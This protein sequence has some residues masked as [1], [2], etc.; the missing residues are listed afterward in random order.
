M[1]PAL[2]F[3]ALAERQII[4]GLTA[5]PSRNDPVS[6]SLRPRRTAWT[7]LTFRPPT[8]CRHTATPRHPSPHAWPDLLALMTIEEKLAQLGSAWVF[9]L[10]DHR[11]FDVAAATGARRRH[12][13]RHT[14]QRRAPRRRRRV[15]ARQRHPAPPPR[16]HP[17]RG[18]GDRARGDLRRP[19]RPRGDRVPAGDRRGRHIP[20]RAQSGDHRRDPPSRCARSAPTRACR[21]CSTCA[22]TRGGVASRRP[23][24]RTRTSSS[25]WASRSCVAC[26]ATSSPTAWWPPPSTSSATARPRAGSTGRR[27]TS[28]SG[29]CATSISARSRPPCATAPIASVMNGYHELDGVPCGADHWLLTELLRDEWGFDGTVVSDYFSVRQLE[30]YHHVAA[31]G[32][33]PPADRAARRPRRR[34]AGHRL[35]RHRAPRRARAGAVS[36]GEID[37]RGGPRAATKFRLGL[38]E[39][40]FVDVD[41]VDA[42]HRTETRRSSS[43]A[44]SPA[45][46]SCC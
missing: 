34:A 7:P 24:A 23:T 45:R 26:R 8:A 46:A 44:R 41:R 38:F 6:P 9:E 37:T 35:L 42:R 32:A 18:A 27:R 31:T 2:L 22:A 11:G 3:Y 14:H 25:R 12:R 40:P 17:P 28:P 36:I 39:Q 29:S 33:G 20:P 1:V 10:A 19:D 30:S 13:A 43:P 21:R 16:A 4:G 15:H 5:A